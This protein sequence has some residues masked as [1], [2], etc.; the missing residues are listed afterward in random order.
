MR[1]VCGEGQ[2][3]GVCAAVDDGQLPL[4]PQAEHIPPEEEG[5]RRESHLTGGVA[6]G[7]CGST[8]VAL[9]DVRYCGGG[10]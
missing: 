4:V 9:A 8:Q 3:G 6:M 10:D 1:L 7:S 5:W 2:W